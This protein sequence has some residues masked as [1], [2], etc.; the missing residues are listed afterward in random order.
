MNG[1][2]TDSYHNCDVYSAMLPINKETLQSKPFQDGRHFGYFY[3]LMIVKKGFS[4]N[5]N[6]TDS[7]HNCDVYSA[8]LPINK[9]TLQSKPFQDGRHF[10][11]FYPLM[12]VKK[13]EYID[14]ICKEQIINVQIKW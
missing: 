6:C 11:Y 7:Y 8:M 14:R 13:G 4:L 12:I 10:G 1:N 9:E 2:C 3:P 5:G